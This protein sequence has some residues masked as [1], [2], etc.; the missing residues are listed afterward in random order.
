MDARHSR[1]LLL[2]LLL[3]RQKSRRLRR[4]W[5]RKINI[6]RLI[7]GEYHSLIAEMRMFDTESF[8]KYFRMTPSRFDHLLS[9][10]GTALY[11]KRTVMRSPVS[12]GERLAVTL[13]FLAT[14]D[15]MKTIAFSYRL[16]HSTVCKIIDDTC[17]AIWNALAVDYLRP[18]LSEATISGPEPWVALICVHFITSV[19]LHTYH[20]Q[21][22]Q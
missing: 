15:S 16:G 12:P 1:K 8:F 13:R 22:H 21:P 3:R 9:L 5:V 17:E 7:K 20:L 19:L 18:S 2:L 11:R 4:K 6:E 14:G 10:I